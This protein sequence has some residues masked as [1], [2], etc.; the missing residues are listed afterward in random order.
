MSTNDT[1]LDQLFKHA[2]D[3]AEWPQAIES[4]VKVPWKHEIAEVELNKLILDGEQLV[5]FLLQALKSDR[6]DN[7]ASML[8][9][10]I[11]SPT[12][13]A[14]LQSLL[15]DDDSDFQQLAAMTLMRVGDVAFPTIQS[16]L[17]SPGEPSQ[18]LLRRMSGTSWNRENDR[19]DELIEIA[20]Q[21]FLRSV[22]DLI[23]GDSEISTIQEAAADALMFHGVNETSA[24]ERLRPLLDSDRKV[25]Q[26]Q[27]AGML[28]GGGVEIERA[29]DLGIAGLNEK[30][31]ELRTL[32]A[33]VLGRMG[34]SALRGVPFLLDHLDEKDRYASTA[35][36]KSLVAIGPIGIPDIVQVMNN[37][38]NPRVRGRCAAV[39]SGKAAVAAFDDLHRLAIEDPNGNVRYRASRALKLIKPKGNAAYLE[40]ILCN[41]DHRENGS[42]RWRDSIIAQRGT[43]VILLWECLVSQDEKTRELTFDLVK[44]F[45]L[46]QH[47]TLAS[48]WVGIELDWLSSDEPSLIHRRLEALTLLD[49]YLSYHESFLRESAKHPDDSIRELASELLS[50]LD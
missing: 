14:P 35:I 7:R 34:E 26:L 42:Y 38:S 21:M 13:I 45:H 46:H 17:V 1:W 44:R 48:C 12:C 20:V 23:N 6:A 19:T 30:E 18:L 24:V 22:S 50:R 9:G 8:L 10:L 29:I 27:V 5:P 2:S 47:E 25:V 43:Y 3:K 40:A 33:K 11:A 28:A 36:K 37:S 41:S 39:L 4:L 15:M 32:A 31:P 49:Q 16:F